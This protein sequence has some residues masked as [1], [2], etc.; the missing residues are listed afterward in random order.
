M[1]IIINL[2]Y[3]TLQ[4]AGVSRYAC[5]LLKKLAKIDSTNKYYLL[6]NFLKIDYFKIKAKNFKFI[7]FKFPINS[8]SVR[9]IV[10]QIIPPIFSY[11]I[12][13]DVIH[14]LNNTAPLLT[15]KTSIVTIHDLSVFFLKN[16][17]ETLKNFYLKHGT[18]LSAKK[19]TH[20]LT[21]SNTTK[22]AIIKFFKIPSIK[23]SV[24]YNGIDEQFYKLKPEKFPVSS[25]YFLFVG[26]IEP[27]KN[28]KNLI[29]AFI[30]FKTYTSN[31]IKLILAGNK[32]YKSEEIF[33]LKNK[34]KFKNDIIFTGYVSD[35]RLRWLYE[36]AIAFVFPSLH[37]G[38]GIPAIEAMALKTPVLASNIEILKEICADAALYFNP[39]NIEE[40]SLSMQKIISSKKLRNKLIKKGQNNIIKFS[41]QKTAIKTLEIYRNSRISQF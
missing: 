18:Y 21:V 22:K 28:I 13:P 32:G 5:N 6:I 26:T 11:I 30:L 34:S 14:S 4:S 39:Y 15:N 12:N 17:Y 36:N 25:P 19:A 23:I 2:L 16:R 8:A 20:I 29:K 27:G 7:P 3:E 35:A 40:L 1:K 10:E 9:R 33:S 41:F 31:N 37:E 38:F 24:T